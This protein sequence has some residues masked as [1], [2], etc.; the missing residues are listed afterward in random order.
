MSSTGD[1]NRSNEPPPS[2][3]H[4]SSQTPPPHLQQGFPG[5]PPIVAWAPPPKPGSFRPAGG[6]L[7]KAQSQIQPLNRPAPFSSLSAKGFVPTGGTMSSSGKEHPSAVTG[8]GNGD[9]DS[10][11]DSEGGQTGFAQQERSQ[12]GE[13]T[14]MTAPQSTQSQSQD[15][16]RRSPLRSRPNGK[17]Q[18]DLS[19]LRLGGNNS[20]IPPPVYRTSLSPPLPAAFS[21]AANPSQST[22]SSSHSQQPLPHPLPSSIPSSSSSNYPP[23]P[24]TSSV[25]QTQSQRSSNQIP[26]KRA[27]SNDSQSQSQL[28][29]SPAPPALQPR[30]NSA[31]APKKT[32]SITSQGGGEVRQGQVKK[33][34]FSSQVKQCVEDGRGMY[35]ALSDM[36]HVVQNMETEISS[37][38]DQLADKSRQ[39]LEVTEEKEQFKKEFTERSRQ[40]IKKVE[41]ANQA[42]ATTYSEA[43][44]A[45]TAQDNGNSFSTVIE[46]LRRDLDNLK[47]DVNESVVGVEG[48]SKL[49]K[50]EG[51][52][53]EIIRELQNKLAGHEGV[54]KLL[55]ADLE[56]RTGELSEARDTISTLNTEQQKA[57][58]RIDHLTSELNSTRS[59]AHQDKQKL[60]DQLEE[61]LLDA[62]EREQSLLKQN[63]TS[64]QKWSNALVELKN[65]ENK[66]EMDIRELRNLKQMKEEEINQTWKLKLSELQQKYEDQIRT[67]S[68]THVSER[69]ELN[70]NLKVAREQLES[71]NGELDQREQALSRAQNSVQ[72]LVESSDRDQEALRTSRIELE[73]LQSGLAEKTADVDNYEVRL[74]D[75]QNRLSEAESSAAATHQLEIERIDNE[76]AQALSAKKDLE[77]QLATFKAEHKTLEATVSR[78]ESSLATAQSTNSSLEAKIVDLVAKLS[79]S[80]AM[81]SDL[82]SKL[83][84]KDAEV[85]ELQALKERFDKE[86]EDYANQE[87]EKLSFALSERYAKDKMDLVNENKRLKN[88]ILNE[89]KKLRKV[90]TELAEKQGKKVLNPVSSSNG[91]AGS[92]GEQRGGDVTSEKSNEGNGGSHKIEENVDDSQSQ[93][94]AT[95][96]T[97]LSLSAIEQAGSLAEDD[98]SH[99]SSGLSPPS[100]SRVIEV[101][102]A[103]GLGGGEVGTGDHTKVANSSIEVLAPQTAASSHLRKRSIDNHEDDL[104]AT[105]QALVISRPS[106]R[107]RRTVSNENKGP[108]TQDEGGSNSKSRLRVSAQQNKYEATTKKKK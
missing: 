59:S 72:A 52:R 62:V 28:Q 36:L 102:Q 49:E 93:E 96:A 11:R 98:K 51:T 70:F 68:N 79:D 41:E 64:M 46:E 16:P 105:E 104:V 32:H 50:N 15:E 69:L 55:R 22:S 17:V 6:G 103:L 63:E 95:T 84:T 19:H 65:A 100:F 88:Q 91:S 75:L 66:L 30:S 18:K 7:V 67:L 8:G 42:L 3:S 82:D 26:K 44:Q 34:K 90:Q 60:R 45:L 78:L 24:S 1:L 40:A 85:K 71:L 108:R 47:K 14:T 39:V 38:N 58:S 54:I 43:R 48:S 33:T 29:N 73:Q 53:V 83:E 27:Y 57:F 35:G 77:E 107:P 80:E 89:A 31:T 92:D 5:S 12:Q 4:N 86:K 81:R 99:E 20:P 106:K 2:S 56:S 61:A 13:G 9:G 87:K 76:K 74:F 10:T 23:T 37:L 94:E 25:N 97:R 21:H 101:E